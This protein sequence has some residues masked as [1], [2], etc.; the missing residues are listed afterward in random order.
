[1]LPVTKDQ[2]SAG[3]IAVGEMSLDPASTALAPT[4]RA[5][6]VLALQATSTQHFLTLGQFC[7]IRSAS[8]SYRIEFQARW[9][10]LPTD[11]TQ[12]M[13]LAFAHVDDRYYE[14][15]L[16][17]S[18][19]YHA[20]HTAQ[21]SLGLYRHGAGSTTAIPLGSNVATAAPQLGRW[22]RFRLDVTPTSLTWS[23]TDGSQPAQVL[24]DDSHVR[25]GYLHIGRTST[26]GSLSFRHFSIT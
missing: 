23:R 3:K 7:P 6:G 18:D 2:W 21:G 9:D 10:Q 8:G 15:G 17:R 26:D 13:S 1:V 25:G 24:A 14:E 4:L 19:G 11:R 16:G 5:G 12:N 22:M 20:V